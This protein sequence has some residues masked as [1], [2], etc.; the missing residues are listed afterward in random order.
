MGNRAH[1][2]FT[3]A[4]SISP[5]VYLHWNGGAESV[6][7]FLAEVSRR[8]GGELPGSSDYACARFVEAAGDFFDAEYWGGGLSLGVSNGPSEITTDA[9]M[10]FDHGDNG[11][12]VVELRVSGAEGTTHTVR[13]FTAQARYTETEEYDGPGPLTEWNSTA[14]DNERRIQFDDDAHG[15]RVALADTFAIIDGGRPK[16]YAESRER[17][18]KDSDR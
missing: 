5:A 15:Y 10:P 11:V 17:E 8:Y 4:H 12:Y 7:A 3:D 6:Y 1:V 18:R 9:L 2:I 14:V 13:R 16:D